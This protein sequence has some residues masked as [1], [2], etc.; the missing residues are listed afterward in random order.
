MKTIR[1]LTLLIIFCCAFTASHAQWVTIPD[2]AFASFLR[3]NYAA[4]MNGNQ[5]DTI[6]IGNLNAYS[7]DCK[8]KNIRNLSGVQYF[9][10]LQFLD[11]DHNALTALPPFP[12]NMFQIHVSYNKL[13]S[14]AGLPDTL[15]NL[16]ADSNLITAL[17]ATLPVFMSALKV[18]N[19]QLT[20]LP[21]LPATLYLLECKNNQISTLPALPASLTSLN[22]NS[23]RLDSLPSLP[24]GLQFLECFN[25]NL[26]VLPSL[27]NTLYIVRCGYN[28]L[29]R[30]SSLPDSLRNFSCF[31]NNI[32]YLPPQLPANVVYFQ[33]N[34][35]LLD[36][37]P[38]IGGQ[39]QALDCRN[40]RLTALPVLP[41][42]LKSLDC[43]GNLL[44]SLP[45]LA[46][47]LDWLNCHDNPNLYCLPRLKY[48]QY[49]SFDSSRVRCLPNYGNV[50][51]STP[52]VTSVPLCQP[53]NANGCISNWNVAGAVFND[54][55]ADCAKQFGE[56]NVA[57]L[58]VQ[59]LQNNN[60]VQQAYT[61][62]YGVY[63]FLAD[64]GNYTLTL[65]TTGLPFNIL[66]PVSQYDSAAVDSGALLNDKDFALQCK[67]G[68]DVAAFSIASN[69]GLFRP[70]A[71]CAFTNK[72]RR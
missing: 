53:G 35:N 57:F 56:D 4:C 8:Y 51:N 1:L 65:D 36:S 54:T 26:S 5:M 2:T 7:I 27:P 13:N 6:C 49:F 32:T 38:K 21:T 28:N 42:T 58:K 55:T 24:A 31:L 50:I 59:L 47:S 10:K 19:N 12:S 34:N 25:N 60:V 3:T 41:A 37:L 22:V 23:N 16:E 39:L 72:S 14:L 62:S 18:S 20:T 71:V 9:D 52:P 15:T 43:N 64:T 46:D 67:P 33:C 69:Y 40:N 17:P 44:T 66:C 63:S 68:Y 29:S 11:C 45:E 30:V 61:G 70:A 48:I